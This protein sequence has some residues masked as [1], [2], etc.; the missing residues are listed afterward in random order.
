MRVALILPMMI[1]LTAGANAAAPTDITRHADF[2]RPTNT[3]RVADPLQIIFDEI[4]RKTIR[5]YYDGNAAVDENHTDTNDRAVER[6]RPNGKRG[7]PPGL[8]KRS[9]LPPGLQKHLERNGTLP[10]GLAK[11][12]LPADLERTLPALPAGVERI[13]VDDD[14]IL[15]ETAT[16]RIL[17][18]IAGALTP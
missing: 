6:R 12:A 2:T 16:G 18:I 5:D 11:R 3:A 1:A 17:D 7:L 15:I 14:L 10:P 8:A 9:D 13:T 4:S